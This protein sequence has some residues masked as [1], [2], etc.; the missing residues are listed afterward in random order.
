MIT[1]EQLDDNGIV[2]RT[3]TEYPRNASALNGR[4][5]RIGRAFNLDHTR[6]LVDGVDV[7]MDLP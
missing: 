4:L 2:Y 7:T 5:H 1:I 6:V 3:L